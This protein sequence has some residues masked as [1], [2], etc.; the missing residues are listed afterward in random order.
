[1]FDRAGD[2]YAQWRQDEPSNQ[3]VT[4]RLA[5]IYAKTGRLEEAERL[6]IGLQGAGGDK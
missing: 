5:G 6:L 2:L 3:A 4:R 1:Q